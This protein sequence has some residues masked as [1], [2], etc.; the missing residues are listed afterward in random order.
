MSDETEDAD[1]VD[2]ELRVDRTAFSV[3]PLDDDA[4]KR[5]WHSRTPE[6]RLRHVE[7]LRRIA[8]GRAATER[9]ERV[10]EVVQVDW[11]P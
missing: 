8:Y 10:F 7:L 1:A 9:I 11:P 5:Y 2:S 4:E 6:E 3:V